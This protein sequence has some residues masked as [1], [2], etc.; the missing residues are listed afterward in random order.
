M[1]RAAPFIKDVCSP[2]KSRNMM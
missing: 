2:S 1:S